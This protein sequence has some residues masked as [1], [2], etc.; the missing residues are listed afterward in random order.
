MAA[1]VSTTYPRHFAEIKAVFHSGSEL[2]LQE[3][4]QDPIERLL[5]R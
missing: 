3:S 5:D 1:V 4:R 2:E